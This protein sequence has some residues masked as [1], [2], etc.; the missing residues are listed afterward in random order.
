MR[1][2]KRSKATSIIFDQA[3][4]TEFLTEGKISGRM[5]G[6]AF[7]ISCPPTSMGISEEDQKKTNDRIDAYKA[8]VAEQARINHELNTELAE[9][10]QQK[11]TIAKTSDDLLL[12]TADLKQKVAK[13]K[14]IAKKYK[15]IADSQDLETIPIDEHQDLLAHKIEEFSKKIEDLEDAQETE[16]NKLEDEIEKLKDDLADCEN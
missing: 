3:D 11:T 16:I 6:H 12:E 14:K 2:G 5:R 4:L 13:L 1:F 10:E 15:K 8:T 9:L 7:L